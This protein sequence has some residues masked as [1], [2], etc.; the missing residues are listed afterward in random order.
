MPWN[1]NST[2][3]PYSILITIAATAVIAFVVWFF[4]RSIVGY[5]FKSKTFELSYKSLKVENFEVFYKQLGHGPD[6][7]LIHGIGASQYSWRLLAPLLAENYTV[8]SIDLPGF[9]QSSKVVTASYDLDSQGER[10]VQIIRELKLNK[11]HIVGSSM[12]GTLAFWVAKKY[13]ELIDHVCGISPATNPKLVPPAV[14]KLAWTSV[15]LTTFVNELTIKQALKKIYVNKSLVNQ[16]SIANYLRPYL[17]NKDAIKVFI[18]SL[19]TLKDP[20]LPQIFAD[21]KPP[22]MVLHGIQD[23]TVPKKRLKEFLDLNPKI[24][25]DETIGGHHLME[26]DP[27]WT[28]KK[29]LW[30]FNQ[31][32]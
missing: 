8:T 22:T 14:S 11:P 2:S 6:V 16:E 7:L 5:F 20:R 4:A 13:P 17:Y 24:I 15:A 32:S 23:T 28:A 12:G 21:L 19:A 18:K 3:D 29:L 30:F 25:Y 9:G 10:L 31:R 1:L 26:D 27:E